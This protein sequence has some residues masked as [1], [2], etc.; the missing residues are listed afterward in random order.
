MGRIAKLGLFG[1][2]K[3]QDWDFVYAALETV[4]IANLKKRQIGQLSGGQQ[5]WMFIAR[6]LAQEAELMLMDEPLTGLDTPSQESLLS[7]RL[8]QEPCSFS[9]TSSHRRY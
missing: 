4:G 2:P 5:Q 6:T 9:A 3:K 8:T 1:W 7:F